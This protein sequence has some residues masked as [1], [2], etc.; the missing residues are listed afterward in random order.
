MTY[1]SLKDQKDQEPCTSVG[2][3]R[4]EHLQEFSPGRRILMLYLVCL[5]DTD[6]LRHL[7]PDPVPRTPGRSIV[8]RVTL[9]RVLCLS[10]AT[11]F[12]QP[13]SLGSDC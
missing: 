8:G 11:F 12:M 5:A 2:A 7:T 3:S 10:V 13:E 9:P 6:I 1:G 4:K